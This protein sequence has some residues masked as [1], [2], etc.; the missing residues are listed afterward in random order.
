[1]SNSPHVRT[2]GRSYPF[3]RAVIH[4]KVLRAA[5]ENPDE[6]ATELA[7]RVSGASAE[8][9][10]QVL[11]DYGDPGG[12]DDAECAGSAVNGTG[13]E[14]ASADDDA[15]TDARPGDE[16][17]TRGDAQTGSAD[18]A[19]AVDPDDDLLADLSAIQRETL[20]AVYR[21]PE[22]TQRELADHLG[23]SC[24]TVN[25]RLNSIEGF[26][27]EARTVFVES[28]FDEVDGRPGEALSA[29]LDTALA[30]KV[31]TL[32][33]RI[34]ALEDRI[35]NTANDSRVDPALAQKVVHV[36][37]SSDRISEDEELQVVRAMFGRSDRPE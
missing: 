31:E 19:V 18:S 34:A 23:V 3:P 26:T 1:M 24:A 37:V 17:A 27:W 35:G 25:R 2:T 21:H 22:A 16:S 14:N 5:E 7:E 13:V 8:L 4:K 30:D 15:A 32:S 9:V 29:S 20:L 10:E 36:C 11:E 12:V 6:P 33:D 28:V